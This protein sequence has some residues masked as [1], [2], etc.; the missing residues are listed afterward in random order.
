MVW[1]V[2]PTDITEAKDQLKYDAAKSGV[3]AYDYMMRAKRLAV[4]ANISLRTAQEFI[5]KYGTLVPEISVWQQS[6]KQQVI[7]TGKL[8][9][10]MGRIRQC[11][12]ACGMLT[13]TGEMSDE[14]LRDLVS[15]I[16]QS[17]VPDVL[18]EGM[19]TLWNNLEWVKWHQQGH[20]SYLASGP[21]SQTAEFAELSNNAANV[22]FRIAQRDCFIPSEF[23][24]GY[25]WGAMLKYKSGEP[26]TYEAWQSRAKQEGYFEEEKIKTKLYSLF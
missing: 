19:W 14:I 16:P 23:Q 15:H 9:T 12:R 26:T 18:N 10:P 3:H 1:N 11:Y 24:W 17:T 6:I 22:H 4:E 20:D 5:T 25:L 7:K 13:N 8:T 2:P 21:P